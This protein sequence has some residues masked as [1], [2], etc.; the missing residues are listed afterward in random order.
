[1][2]VRLLLEASNSLQTGL[3]ESFRL[4]GEFYLQSSSQLV[5]SASISV[6]L[7]SI[8]VTAMLNVILSPKDGCLV[9]CDVKF[10]TSA[11]PDYSW[12]CSHFIWNNTL[13]TLPKGTV[14]KME[15]Y[16]CSNEE[17]SKWHLL[18]WAGQSLW[19]DIVY[20][21]IEDWEKGRVKQ[22]S[23]MHIL[24]QLPQISRFLYWGKGI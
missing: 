24:E 5:A 19:G 2:D 12:A 16:K 15:H 22:D 8:L 18:P 17:F 20:R 1:M 4:R 3:L 23:C 21:V 13:D 10:S 11:F 7:V 6:Y 9:N 14:W